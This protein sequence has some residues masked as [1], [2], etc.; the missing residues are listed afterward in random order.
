MISKTALKF[1]G[2]QT[3]LLRWNV[4]DRTAFQNARSLEYSEDPCFDESDED[5]DDSYESEIDDSM[6]AFEAEESAEPKTELGDVF[7]RQEP[8][9]S[10][11][12]S[13]ISMT[14]SP[15]IDDIFWGGGEPYIP[16]PDTGRQ[17]YS[18]SSSSSV[19]QYCHIQPEKPSVVPIPMPPMPSGEAP[20]PVSKLGHMQAPC[21]FCQCST[22]ASA[23]PVSLVDYRSTGASIYSSEDSVDSFWS[24]STPV[25]IHTASSSESVIPWQYQFSRWNMGDECLLDSNIETIEDF[26]PISEKDSNPECSTFRDESERSGWASVLNL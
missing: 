11:E 10:F 16:R 15:D 20:V 24:T 22:F 6:E 8:N 18:F 13:S 4:G 9:E 1:P 21:R 7:C 17:E 5:D 26:I 3:Q 19:A 25:S 2:G 12:E 14:R 23:E